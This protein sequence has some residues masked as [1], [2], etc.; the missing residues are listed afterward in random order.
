MSS[1]R[2]RNLS[3][4][5]EKL[6]S[7]KP[8]ERQEGRAELKTAFARQSAVAEVDGGDGKGWN[9]LFSS[10]IYSVTEERTACLKSGSLPT[11]T[12]GAGAQA[13]RRLREAAGTV[14]WLVELS[15]RLLTRKIVN[16]ILTHVLQCMIWRGELLEPV[17]SDYV[18]TIR[19]I[20]NWSPHLQHLDDETWTSLVE[21]GFNVVL[22]D[23]YSRRLD[24]DE[25]NENPR[26]DSVAPS[27]AVDREDAYVDEDDDGFSTP[28]TITSVTSRKRRRPPEQPSTSRTA[29]STPT[30]HKGKHPATISVVQIDF[31]SILVTLLQSSSAP[32]LSVEFHYLPA[33]L[34]SRFHGF[35]QKYSTE[36]S[37]HHDFLLA[38]SATLSHLALNRCEKVANFAR[39]AWDDLL[40]LWGT[41]NQR[42]KEDLIIVL[43]R[44]FPYLSTENLDVQPMPSPRYQEG[45]MKLWKLLSGEAENRWGVEELSLESLRLQLVDHDS[46]KDSGSAFV[47]NTFRHGWQLTAAQ[48]LTWAILE[49]QADCAKQLYLLSES[50][51]A[52]PSDATEVKGKRVRLVDPITSLLQWLKLPLSPTIHAYR[53]QMLLFFVDKS[54][55]VLHDTLQDAT[56]TTLLQLISFEDG[57]IQSWAF[58]CLA[59]IAY[60]EGIAIAAN[61]S[62]LTSPVVPATH[63]NTAWTHAM[64]RINVHVVSRA[65]CHAACSFL[66]FAR[67]SISQENVLTEIE[68]LAKDLDVQGPPF[69]YDS[70]CAF[71]A[72]CIQVVSQD[73]RLYRMQYE[74]RILSWLVDSWRI[75][76]E[77]R[78]KQPLHTVGDVVML[79]ENI[80]S[81][82]KT[83][84]PI[85]YLGLPDCRIVDFI[86][87]E[88]QHTIIR[89]FVLYAHLPPYHS[90]DRL[91]R[92]FS[93][94]EEA[95]NALDSDA[96]PELSHLAQPSERE[97]RISAMLLKMIEEATTSWTSHRE[98]SGYLSAERLRTLLDLS[99][100]SLWFESTLISNGTVPNKRVQ[101]AACRMIGLLT[102]A[103]ADR[104]WIAEERAVILSGMWP[105]VMVTND[106]SLHMPW[107][108]FLPPDEGS[109]I[110]RSILKSLTASVNGDY[111]RRQVARRTLQR[112]IMHA[113][114]VQDTLSSL[115]ALMRD[116]IRRVVG[117]MGSEASQ[118]QPSDDD[119]FGP[120]R[121]I[122]DM[123]P[124]NP[125]QQSKLDNRAS[126]TVM[127]TCVSALA[128]VPML[129]SPS[130]EPTRDKDLTDIVMACDSSSF[131]VLAST[132][133]AAIRHGTLAISISTLDQLL[134]R[135]EEL[136]TH[137]VSSRDERS[138]LLTI[139]CLDSTLGL[140]LQQAPV[141]SD[142]GSKIQQLCHYLEKAWSRNR[143]RSWKVRDELLR[144]FDH[145]LIEDPSQ[146][147]WFTDVAEPD[148]ERCPFGLLPRL[149]V[150]HDIRVRFRAVT[151]NARLFRLAPKRDWDPMNLYRSIQDLFRSFLDSYEY[152]LT[153]LLCLGNI[154]VVS[155]AIRRGPY[156]H[157]LETC[158][159]KPAFTR[160]I[161]SV[162]R[163]IGERLGLTSSQLFEVYASQI[164]FSLLQ[165]GLSFLQ[166]P[167]HLLGYSAKRECA[168]ATFRAFTPTNLL[169][170]SSHQLV[171]NGQNLFASHCNALQKP[172]ADGIQECFGDI[173]GYQIVISF[174]ED[175]EPE[176][177]MKTLQ[178]MTQDM[179]HGRTL[180]QMLKEDVPAIVVAI[181]RTL[182]DQAHS[183]GSLLVKCLGESSA[184]AAETFSSLVKYREAEIFP[185]HLPN[186]PAFDTGTVVRS[187]LWFGRQAPEI[188][189]TEATYHVLHR[190]LAE[191]ERSPLVNEQ[192][193]LINAACIW[194]AL[195]EDHF[196]DP[197]LLYTL[198]KWATSLLAQIDL[199]FASQSI[200]EWV[201]AR[202]AQNTE[203][204]GRLP[205]LL[206]HIS[207]TAHDY[208]NDTRDPFVSSLGQSLMSWIQDQVRLLSENDALQQYIIKALVAWP[209][210]LPSDLRLLVDDVAPQ[211]LSR[212]LKDPHISASKFRL[213]RR[214]CAVA[215]ERGYDQDRFVRSDFWQL[216]ECIPPRAQVREEDIDA[217]ATLLVTHGN[218]TDTFG[219]ESSSHSLRTRHCGIKR[220]LKGQELAH[221]QRTI[222][223]SLVSMLDSVSASHVNVAYKT[224]CSLL[225]VHEPKELMPKDSRSDI[226]DELRHLHTYPTMTVQKPSNDLL[227]FLSKSSSLDLVGDF[228]RWISQ[229]T[230][231]LS[232]F[233]AQKD[234]FFAPLVHVLQSDTAFAE[235][236]LPILVYCVLQMQDSQSGASPLLRER[237]SQYFMSILAAEE[238]SVPSLR[239]VVD[240]ILHLRHFN[241]VKAKDALARD[242]WL[243][244]DYVLLSQSALRCGAFTTALLF[245]ELGAEYGQERALDTTVTEDILFEI[246]S[247]IDEPDGFYGV[248]TNDLRRFLVRRLHHEGQWEKAFRLHGAAFEVSTSE[249]S[250]A[251]GL[252]HSLHAFGFD[253]LAMSTL[254][255]APAS[256]ASNLSL[257]YHMAWRTGSWDLPGRPEERNSG[258]SLYRVMRAIHRERSESAINTIVHDVLLDE[259]DYLRSLGNE[260]MAEIREVSRTLMCLQQVKRW[261]D[262]VIQ[263]AFRSKRYDV[264]DRVAFTQLDFDR[265]F[266]DIEPVMMSRVSLARSVRQKEQREQIG[267]LLSEFSRNIVSFETRTLLELAHSARRAYHPQIALNAVTRAQHLHLH[268]P[269]EVENEF[270]D[271]LWVMKEPKLA[272]QILATLVRRSNELPATDD[273]SGLRSALLLARLGAWSAEASLEK[274]DSIVKNYFMPA[275]KRLRHSTSQRGSVEPKYA[276]VYHQYALF[277]DRQYH[278]IVNSPDA[279]RSKLYVDRKT[280][281][282]RQRQSQIQNAQPQSTEWKNLSTQQHNAKRLLE[283]DILQFEEY[284]HGRDQ[285]LARAVE[286]YA[287][288]LQSCDDFDHDAILSLCRLWMATFDNSDTNIDFGKFLTRVPSH[289]FIFLAHQLSARLSTPHSGQASR[290]QQVLQYLIT[291]MCRDHPFHS[292]Y[293]VFCLKGDSDMSEASTSNRRLSGRHEPSPAQAE[294]ASAASAIFNRLRSDALCQAR[295]QDVELVCAAS[296]EWAKHPVKE[297][298]KK[299]GQKG[300]SIP[301]NLKIRNLRNIRVPVI[302]TRTPPDP[303]LQYTEFVTIASFESTYAVLGGVN[304]PKVTF[305]VG[306]NGKR[307]KQLYK[308]E[309]N[310]DLRQDA[311]MEQVFDLV[312]I[313]LRK[314]RAARRRNLKVRDYRVIPL[315]SQAGV[316]EFVENTSTLAEWLTNAHPR[317]RPDDT[318]PSTAYHI[319]DK[320]QKAMKGDHA[321]LTEVFLQVRE[322]F[323]PVMRHYF[324]EKHKTPMSWFVMR[325]NYTRSVAT[326]SIVGHILGLGD[327]HLSNILIDNS[328]GELAHID[329]GIAFDQGKLL[330]MPERVPFRLT[331]DMVDGMGMS[332]T[333]GVFQRCSEETLRVLRDES[334]VILTVLEVFKYDP[335]HSWTASELKIKRVQGSTSET[336]NLTGEALRFAL[337]IDLISGAADEAA[338]RALSSVKRK[339]DKT[340]SA[341]YVV[342]DLIAEA[343]DV[344]NLGNMF[345]GAH[346]ISYFWT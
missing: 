54:W 287:T 135:L 82:S 21:R 80:C 278:V 248:K 117:Q 195:H 295:V 132:Y 48:A 315:A 70:V 37:I 58:L 207:C 215:A 81:L 26:E 150:D 274:P 235:E 281:E 61:N 107:V 34:M 198:A 344:N 177:I 286:M 229:V 324:T 276:A 114:E 211:D 337:G 228:P 125:S 41:K 313:L 175:G 31:M 191:L 17:T 33:A 291:R 307:Y 59:A 87:E 192:I 316:L 272:V 257:T 296:L 67:R 158:L 94:Q 74:D 75:P 304:V 260:N 187:L 86:I 322:K 35:L 159:Y 8:K 270:A 282:I 97:R 68:T 292:L 164:A 335:L 138:Q 55:M 44:L 47:G 51:H 185:A 246:F 124:L 173:V 92:S 60:A 345:G 250:D 312:N 199:A 103:I 323:K 161:E 141:S 232:C 108:T 251:G 214:L 213:A 233:M 265:D 155:S 221:S 23:N 162:L 284:K 53:L 145:Y 300:G 204:G 338:D 240:I 169:S 129:R 188:E 194:V 63:W 318:K 160:H 12:T 271:V 52:G 267:D 78:L 110:R 50:A 65:A 115:M 28:S 302:T 136:L 180:A 13:V 319:M 131:F 306:S 341:E 30:P 299:T 311:V 268:P 29:R 259:M 342:N 331:A 321:A 5:V 309:G 172:T 99:I 120:V 20:L 25:V 280:E 128:S 197:T 189:D 220:E 245:L 328:S 340:L 182:R 90:A 84:R 224:L 10:V 343:T 317:Y 181:L 239:S 38:L 119:G 4:T 314:D 146:S 151:A 326:T 264:C 346:T 166:F 186:L 297:Y 178:Q 184:R 216:K 230:R 100:T 308:G 121:V 77:G 269:S 206:I 236:A 217:F 205:N 22:E 336:S 96:I 163:G 241:P 301:D 183:P 98:L 212:V 56:R 234:L 149:M 334:D 293:Q 256:A 201:L 62:S 332:G 252:V 14:R 208:A 109:G 210:D 202:Y 254:S 85:S 134:S 174:G 105:L 179:L 15:V 3:K 266:S 36:T 152:L 111:E 1:D 45:L 144:F 330:P 273:S 298:L 64:R 219:Y 16:T 139:Y 69:P 289:K 89:E 143:L 112:V 95:T 279:L 46:D 73:V 118:P 193:R 19:C 288:T 290:D 171:S 237:L 263:P 157:L 24:E 127:F 88:D 101:H 40:R 285:Y 196:Q 76:S 147:F 339:L 253:H 167:P 170:R 258:A 225:S 294:R 176:N 156:W 27:E 333:Q 142:T 277:A 2:A 11:G 305:C 168:E 6:Q 249:R 137:Y 49:L 227:D 190:M 72:L 261:R 165:S 79:L 247:H 303:T 148:L 222:L 329:L 320:K 327:R 32:L 71:L 203:N 242:K 130:G 218:F 122:G 104:R 243:D 113:P 244:V 226:G 66:L 325:L 39:G 140:W 18:K 133:L 223:I 262:P 238:A 126:H 42:M 83:A 57:V 93:S 255:N 153:R 102:P 43:R 209:E 123:T 116:I 231:Q 106:T 154:V 9:A 200:L 91:R 7:S 275:T 283:L 310:D